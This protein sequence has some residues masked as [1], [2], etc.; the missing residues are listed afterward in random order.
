MGNYVV[1]KTSRVMPW[2]TEFMTE[3]YN[4]LGLSLCEDYRL[5]PHRVT[6]YDKNA[7]CNLLNIPVAKPLEHLEFVFGDR[8]TYSYAGPEKQTTDRMADQ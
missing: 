2:K 1:I 8:S 3:V 5:P 6:P 4:H 7:M